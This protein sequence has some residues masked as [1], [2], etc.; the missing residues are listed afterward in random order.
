MTPTQGT[1]AQ[2]DT[3]WM[4]G[5]VN[6]LVND[7]AA[8]RVSHPDEE[9]IRRVSGCVPIFDTAGRKQVSRS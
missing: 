9:F 5:G 7:T 4:S 6:V 2:P 3:A 1:P 8:D